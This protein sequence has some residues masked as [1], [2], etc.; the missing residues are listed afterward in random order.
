M[1]IRI[2]N[3]LKRVLVNVIPTSISGSKNY[4]EHR[5]SIGG[6]SGRGSYGE[7]AE[8]KA[9]V[10]NKFIVDNK[11]ETAIEFG[12]GDGNQLSLINY[13]NYIGLDVSLTA[14]KICKEQFAEDKTKSFFLYNQE[15]FI[16]NHSI[17][18]AE[19]TLS[20]DVI[21]HLIEDEVYDTYMHQ[22]FL[23]SQ[24]Y[25]IIYSSNTDQNPI[26]QKSHVKHRQF[27]SWVNRNYP[28]WQLLQHI[29]NEVTGENILNPELIADFLIFQLNEQ[30]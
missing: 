20:L 18:S 4:W 3:W 13:P 2:T 23:A 25:V 12:C 21:L 26:V 14:L 22:L 1:K 29:P 8:F 15:C 17:F 28:N 16:D 19:L 10:L 30:K 9:R 5:Y 27:T 11:I 7:W 6:T 24:K